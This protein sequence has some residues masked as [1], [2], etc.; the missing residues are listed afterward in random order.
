M[1]SDIH[2]GRLEKAVTG[3][4]ETTGLEAVY[5][6]LAN[7][8]VEDDVQAWSMLPNSRWTAWIY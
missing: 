7:V 5:G 1:I 2:Q 6:R 3:L 8:T 4:R